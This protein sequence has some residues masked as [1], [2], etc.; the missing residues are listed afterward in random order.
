MRKLL[1]ILLLSITWSAPMLNAQMRA[2]TVDIFMGVDLNYRD[3]AFNNRVFDFLINLTP[4]VKWQLPHRWQISA[5][6][7]VPVFNQYGDHYKHVRVYNAA[8][9]KQLALFGR[10]RMKVSGGVFGSERYGLDIKNMVIINDWLALT[11]ELGVTGY[12]SMSSDWQMSSMKRISGLVGPEFYLH[13]WNTQLSLR[14]GRYTYG[15]YGVMAEC[16]RHFRHVTLGAYASYNEVTH[17]NVGFKIVVMIPPYKRGN[18][19]VNFRPASNFR[20]T[21]SSRT[22]NYANR[23]YIT[24]PEEN[25]REGWFDAD[26]LP[27]GPNTMEPDFTYRDDKDSR[28]REE[29]TK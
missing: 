12:L 20:F 5:G 26:M 24:D 11:A 25:E 21:Y 18:R 16:M 6:V 15:D 19:T 1:L 14:G 4:G 9:S 27:W 8:V 28:K 29:V 3:I 13:R 22:D 17:E 23:T 10:W 2:G 7:L